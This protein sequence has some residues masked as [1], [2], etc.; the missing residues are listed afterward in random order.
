MA[1]QYNGV[2]DNAA[3]PASVGIASTTNATPIV[4]TT[5]FAHGLTEGDQI[6]VSGQLN[7]TAANGI[8]YAHVTGST[9]VALLVPVSHANSVGNGSSTAAGIVQNLSL[10]PTFAEPS[11]GDAASAASVNVALSALGDRTQW[12]SQRT[13]TQRLVAQSVVGT[14]TFGEGPVLLQ[15]WTTN[16][17]AGAY[18][19]GSSLVWN[20]IAGDLVVVQCM[21]GI[22]F[23]SNN[24][25][26]YYLKMQRNPGG[27]AADFTGQGRVVLSNP[28]FVNLIECTSVPMIGRET[29][30]A[31]TAAQVQTSG[32]GLVF[33][34]KSVNPTNFSLTEDSYAVIS[35]YRSN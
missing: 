13:G 6:L 15:T 7:N 30:S 1:S 29:L 33:T 8:W 18:Q 11:D 2:A 19:L 9:T 22:K 26:T 3:R 17:Y 21:L 5:S 27:G 32:W 24:G 16:G 14:S 25:D 35:V 4:V 12:L 31:T 23:T 28:A 20:A 10:T 34:G